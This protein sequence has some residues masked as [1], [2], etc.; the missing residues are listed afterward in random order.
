MCHVVF[1]KTDHPK[2]KIELHI[3]LTLNVPGGVC[4]DISMR[5]ELP[6]W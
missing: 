6:N 3:D 5:V 4:R 1:F 2:K